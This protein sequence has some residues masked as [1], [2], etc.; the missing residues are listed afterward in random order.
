MACT[1]DQSIA[2]TQPIQGAANTEPF[3]GWFDHFDWISK[4]H[5]TIEILKKVYFV[6]RLIFCW[7]EK[8]FRLKCLGYY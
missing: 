3:L 4:L 1:R 7:M 6:Y 5:Q 8:A 2:T